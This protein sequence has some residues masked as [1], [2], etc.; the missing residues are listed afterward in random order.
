MKLTSPFNYE[1]PLHLLL[2]WLYPDIWH[3]TRPTSNYK[4]QSF[5]RKCIIVNK[6]AA[7]KL[8]YLITLTFR[9]QTKNALLHLRSGSSS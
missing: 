3:H 4:C 6:T 2:L 9:R 8:V 5:N 1:Y 7:E